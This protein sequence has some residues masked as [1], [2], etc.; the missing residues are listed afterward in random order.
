[1][2]DSKITSNA[3]TILAMK[4]F[5]L[6]RKYLEA[7]KKEILIEILME[8]DCDRMVTNVC[9]KNRTDMFWFQLFGGICLR[10]K[11]LYGFVGIGTN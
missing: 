5:R 11:L 7:W 2:L 8:I 4:F 10:Q 6:I 9:L 3:N 1:M